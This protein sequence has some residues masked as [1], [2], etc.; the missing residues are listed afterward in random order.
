MRRFLLTTLAVLA[1][2][3]PA[4]AQSER[5]LTAA[6]VQVDL[7]LLPDGSLQ[8][9]EAITFRFSGRSF[10]EVERHVP[11][12]R[13]DGVIDVQALMDG[14]VLPE[15][16]EDGQARVERRRRELRVRWRFPDVTDVSR[17]FTLSFRAMGAARLDHDRVNVAWH[18]LPTRHRYTIDEAVLTWRTPAGTRSIDGP[19]LEAEGWTWS[20]T[21][22][23]H[24]TAR[25]TNLANDETAV[26]IDTLHRDGFA[27]TT[28]VW[29]I[30]D[31]RARELTPAFVVGALV[32]L[33]MG[34]GVVGMT[35]L[36]YHQPKVDA[37]AAVPLEHQALP[38]ALA[39]SMLGG[40]PRVGLSQVSATLVDLLARGA[41]RVEEQTGDGAPRTATAFSLRSD[42]RPAHL[43][44]HEAALFD[45]LWLRMKQGR[46]DLAGARMAVTSA[47]GPFTRAVHDEL[48]EMG[49]VDR[50]RR[51]AARGLLTAALVAVSA[52]LLGMVLL[53]VV[54]PG[55]GEASLLVPG[56]V[57]FLGVG[58]LVASQ[59][60]PTWTGSGAR[61]SAQCRARARDLRAM[62]KR[63]PAAGDVDRWL[64]LAVG[65]GVGRAFSKAGVPVPWLG[66]L[67]DPASVL[68]IIIASSTASSHTG[69]SASGGVA[70]GGGF[71][72]AR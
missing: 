41:L 13:T 59:V 71:S 69:V 2:A 42:Q 15:G 22:E 65:V 31:A 47:L 30:Q 48:L 34:A 9:T 50:E 60:F 56:A 72:G 66:G 44:P 70:G 54:W 29:Q 7:E 45:A 21:P 33:V 14:Q 26:L 46:V 23:G 52:G 51:W 16:R 11:T 64:S 18:V 36:R 12:R 61:L 40:Q 68:P 5:E 6:R 62:A 63:G 38:P 20:R 58:F 57:M 67:T 28:P 27:L 1:V 10:S 24:W 3:A 32:I 39:A 35:F 55:F 53:A 8:V 17:T 19:A 4:V 43:R 37:Q 49:L 25:K